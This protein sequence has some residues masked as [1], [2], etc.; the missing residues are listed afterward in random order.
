[1]FAD[2]RSQQYRDGVDYFVTVRSV[3]NMGRIKCPCVRCGNGETL[4]PNSIKKHFFFNGMNKNYTNWF[5]HGERIVNSTTKNMME[6]TKVNEL[7]GLRRISITWWKWLMM[8]EKILLG[9][10]N[11][12]LNC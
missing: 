9:N 1:M 3:R 4:S 12:L 6:S 10:R 5:C 2:R 8:L 7:F 11:N